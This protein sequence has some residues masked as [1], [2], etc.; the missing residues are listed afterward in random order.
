MADDNNEESRSDNR[1]YP[2]EARSF[3]A[4]PDSESLHLIQSQYQR[5][6]VSLAAQAISSADLPSLFHNTISLVAQ[7][8][9]VQYT[10][11]WQVLSDGSTLQKV[12]STGWSNL[13]AD[14]LEVSAHEQS[15]VG[16]LLTAKSPV[17]IENNQ[18][19][20][21]DL[22]YISPIS[23]PDSVSS[24]CVLI[25]GQE[26]PLGLLTI[27]SL[28][29]YSFVPEVV[30]FLQAVAHLLAAA[31]ERKR[32]EV[33]LSIQTQILESIASGGHL[34]TIYKQLCLLVEQQSPG[35][36]CSILILDPESRQLRLGAAP[37]M[38]KAYAQA[39]DGLM[40]GEQAG[41]CGTSAYYGAPVF[42]TDITTDP[43]WTA[44]RELAL[45]HN[46]RACWSR[47]FFSESGAVLGTFALAHRI[48]CQPTTYH[49]EMMKT[50]THL[51]TL[52]AEGY[53]AAEQ[54]KQK[55]LCDP[56]TGLSNRALFMERLQKEFQEAHLRA[57]GELQPPK[58]FAVLFLDVDHF[59]FV[60]DS[61]GH[62]IGDQ[63]LI[64]ISRRL[65]HCLK[66]K[67][68][69]TRLGGDEF[70]ILLGA[71]ESIV[72]V[73]SVAQRIQSTILCPFQLDGHELFISVSMGI[74]LFDQH[75]QHPE[76]MLRDA[77]AAM[78]QAKGNQR[79][80]HAVF[81]DLTR[82]QVCSR[83]QIELELRQELECLLSNTPARFQLYYQPIVSFLNGSIIGFEALL[84]W[85][86]PDRGQLSPGEFVPVAEENGLIVPIGKWILQEACHQ[87]RQWQEK[88]NRFNSLT[89]SVNISNRQLLQPDFLSQIKKIL[90]SNQIEASCLKLE[91]TETMLMEMARFV[92]PQLES[93]K[94]MGIQLNLDDFGTGYSSLSHL[95]TIP[96]SA[97]KIDRSFT[98]ELGNEHDKV[99][100]TIISLARELHMETIA[101]G[102]ET[103]QQLARLREFG[104]NFGQGY[105]F[106]APVPKEEAAILLSSFPL[107][108]LA[109]PVTQGI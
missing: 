45:K 81:D 77:D 102:V 54:L 38:P 91:I 104:C 78:Y 106:S 33:L 52:A 49:L 32:A 17:L 26:V 83:S 67:D 60:N 109:K 50:V 94:Q 35:A 86:H 69:L 5:T 56:L 76:D 41:S 2:S 72:Q 88:L 39:L 95:H 107:D 10:S 19:S 108:G 79:G 92:A 71:I 30:H 66:P 80:S 34:E 44:F 75:Y 43:R 15:W 68:I 65:E 63:L 59:K 37:S 16:Y 64:A 99:A 1:H 57:Q 23:P 40:L 3:K 25:P 7:T 13:M 85:Q 28:E 11:I 21:L 93:L 87:L 12:A 90:I 20:T 6:I 84:R 24:G 89:I 62:E 98:A 29:P 101:E 18:V 46:I 27:H 22:K 31:I 55:A 48:P 51:A 97:I 36:L 9:G 73:R 96:V 58:R 42:V 100:R 70:A 53:S 8:L 74:A 4:Q 82:S 103:P 105:L 14:R 47:P 61:L